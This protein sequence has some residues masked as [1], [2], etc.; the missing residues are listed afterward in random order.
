MADWERILDRYYGAS[1]PFDTLTVEN[2]Q[3]LTV[4]QAVADNVYFA[5]TVDLPFDTDHSSNAPAAPW[6]FS[7]GSYSGS[8]SAYTAAVAPGTFWAY[9]STSAPV[10]AIEDY[11]R[12]LSQ[13]PKHS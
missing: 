9:H 6:V 12:L 8:L 4:K 2:L 11:V 5:Q 1:S 3:L 13:S 10:E 7:G